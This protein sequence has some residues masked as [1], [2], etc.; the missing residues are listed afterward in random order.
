MH[1]II[2]ILSL[3][4]STTY[5]YS[6]SPIGLWKSV[7]DTDGRE[8]S[9]IQIYESNGKLRGK[10]IKLLPAATT[11]TCNKCKGDKKNKGLVGMDILWGMEKQ[12]DGSYDDG[13][14]LDPATGKIY[15]CSFEVKG[16]QLHVRGY[17]G[18]SLLGRTQT[19]YKV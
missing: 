19:W 17:F 7:D 18:L 2:I 15:D 6:Q 12:K 16:N 14:I 13:E 11:T 3:L 5:A 1:K 9:H 10:I 8:K 4:V